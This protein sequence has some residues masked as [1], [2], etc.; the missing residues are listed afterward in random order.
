MLWRCGGGEVEE[1]DRKA[2][3]GSPWEMDDP[4]GEGALSHCYL[5][6]SPAAVLKA[7]GRGSVS[8]GLLFKWMIIILGV[9][10]FGK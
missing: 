6:M 4:K 1:E 2:R 3:S 7:G 8:D 9:Y 5:L 10:E